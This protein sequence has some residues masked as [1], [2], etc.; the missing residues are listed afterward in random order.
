MT[1]RPRILQRIL[2]ASA[3]IKSCWRIL[4]DSNDA[5]TEELTVVAEDNPFTSSVYSRTDDFKETPM[6][7]KEMSSDASLEGSDVSSR[8]ASTRTSHYRIRG[9]FDSFVESSS[10]TIFSSKY[11]KV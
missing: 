8:I 4:D 2:D 7:Q 9:I 11:K 5:A 3:S 10:Y 1:E 6:K